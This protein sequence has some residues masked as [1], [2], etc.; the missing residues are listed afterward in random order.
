M[1]FIKPDEGKC[2]ILNQD[3][4]KKAHIIQN[5]VGYLAGEIAFINDMSAK[6]YINFIADMKKIKDRNR[7]DELL[8]IFELETNVK[9][10]K[11]SKGMKQKVGIVTA[12][13]GSPEVLI[14]DEPTSGLDP[15]MQ[16]KFVELL[17][18]EKKKGTTIFISSH[19][20]EEIE[21]TCDRTAIIRNDITGDI[22]CCH[23]FP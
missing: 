12:F 18:E 2:T 23:P 20:L 3:C 4:F 13:M 8:K 21:K 6:D 15:L 5:Q 19:M 16:N 7:I 1:G 10:K 22:I 17:L 11:M 14:L 9:I